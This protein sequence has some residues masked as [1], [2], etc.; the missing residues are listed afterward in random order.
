M[1]GLSGFVL[2]QMKPIQTWGWAVLG[3][4]GAPKPMEGMGLR[5]GQRCGTQ[6]L[7]RA[8]HE[9]GTGAHSSCYLH[10][11]AFGFLFFFP[12]LFG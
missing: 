1:R 9:F 2:A 12:L 5:A 8:G 10:H 7:A 11:E 3:L 4:T 6:S